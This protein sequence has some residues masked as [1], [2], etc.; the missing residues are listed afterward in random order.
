MLPERQTRRQVSGWLVRF[1]FFTFTLSSSFFT[2]CAD[3]AQQVAQ[4]SDQHRTVI[5]ENEPPQVAEP[6]DQLGERTN[7]LQQAVLQAEQSGEEVA[8]IHDIPL[9]S[10]GLNERVF[11]HIPHINPAGLAA[12]S[13]GTT[14]CSRIAEHSGY[15]E[16]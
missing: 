3:G 4:P 12:I 7:K 9:G 14:R 2:G 11:A 5:S 15:H 10:A 6:N 13:N 8:A 16:C 1:T